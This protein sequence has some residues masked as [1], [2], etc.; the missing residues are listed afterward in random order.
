MGASD[1]KPR[2]YIDFLNLT[3]K[4]HQTE[5]FNN[6]NNPRIYNSHSVRLVRELIKLRDKF[7]DLY[8]EL[9]PQ[10]PQRTP[11]SRLPQ[12][13]ESGLPSFVKLGLMPLNM[14]VSGQD[15]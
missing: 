9:K 4:E 5:M 10:E 12:K 8:P 6:H 13:T 1:Q 11:E 15:V 14:P 3:I 7:Y 2:Q